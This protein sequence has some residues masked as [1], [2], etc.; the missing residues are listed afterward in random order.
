MA[1]QRHFPAAAQR[2]AVQAANDRF[3]QRFQRAEVLFHPL[4]FGKDGARIR[5]LVAHQSLQVRAGEE[6]GFVGRQ[7]DAA[8]GV[9]VLQH[10]R[11][12]LGQ[13]ALPLQAHGVD[14]GIRLVKGE[15]GDAVAE[16]VLDGFHGDFCKFL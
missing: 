10:L 9:F 7:D 2:R 13:I 4:D 6:G 14:G 11:G 3:A 5:R 12:R 15:G 16:F 8:D 1:D